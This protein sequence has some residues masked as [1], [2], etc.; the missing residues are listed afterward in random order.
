MASQT[1]DQG[2]A[3]YMQRYRIPSGEGILRKIFTVHLPE[4]CLET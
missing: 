3:E 1:Y 4:L 2:H